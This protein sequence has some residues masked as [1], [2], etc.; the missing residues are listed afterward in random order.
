MS[1]SIATF[2]LLRESARGEFAE[3][4]RTEKK[5]T[6]K[7]GLFRTKEIVTGERFLWE[8]LDE[9]A[10]ERIEF[11]HS[12]FV[13]IDYLFTFLEGAERIQTEFAAAAID[14]N[15]YS[16]PGEMAERVA[17]FL[18][19]NPPDDKAL[20]S[21]ADQH[22]AQSPRQH[23]KLLKDTHETLRSWFRRVNGDKFGVLQLTF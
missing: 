17:R 20:E 11:P 13:L 4:K 7:H 12:G 23:A 18:E 9:A 22:G 16:I 1:S 3:A 19:D 2:Y 14:A 6:Y 15:Y 10:E 5:I 8:Y 21:F